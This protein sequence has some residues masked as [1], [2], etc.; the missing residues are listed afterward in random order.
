MAGVGGGERGKMK[1]TVKLPSGHS[2]TVQF[3]DNVKGMKFNKF[4]REMKA[5][6]LLDFNYYLQIGKSA[7]EAVIE[8]SKNIQKVVV[9][10]RQIYGRHPPV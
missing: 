7:D 3:S 4:W 9:E 5:K 10:S 2:L 8:I 1:R 6:T